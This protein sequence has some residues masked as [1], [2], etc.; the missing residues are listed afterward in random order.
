MLGQNNFAELNWHVFT[1][2]HPKLIVQCTDGVALLLGNI[3]HKGSIGGGLGGS[4]N[5]ILYVGR[6]WL[7][8]YIRV[9]FD[10]FGAGWYQ[11]TFISLACG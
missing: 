2:L 10:S 1:F 6:T 5:K 7:G 3:A 8:L 11:G 9:T 4:A